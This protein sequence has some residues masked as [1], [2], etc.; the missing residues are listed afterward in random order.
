M[1]KYTKRIILIVMK[2]IKRINDVRNQN[3]AI[4]DKILLDL[5]DKCD[6]NINSL[7]RCAKALFDLGELKNSSNI[8]IVEMLSS[9]EIKNLI[10]F[11]ELGENIKVLISASSINSL[12]KKELLTEDIKININATD[13]A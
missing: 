5:V 13:V 6:V 9:D 12:I 2:T 7:V 10:N 4:E 8:K 3:K 11:E 1:V